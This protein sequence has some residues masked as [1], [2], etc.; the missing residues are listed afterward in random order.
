MTDPTRRTVPEVQATHAPSLLANRLDLSW[1]EP[2]GLHSTLLS[3]ALVV[4]TVEAFEGMVDELVAQSRAT[5]D[6]ALAEAYVAEAARILIE[7]LGRRE[8]AEAL[9]KR[10]EG[11][12]VREMLGAITGPDAGLGREL[13]ALEREATDTSRPAAERADAWVEFGLACEQHT[14]SLDRALAAYRKAL[15]LVPEHPVALQLAA[16]AATLIDEEAAADL[17]DR[18]LHTDL[19]PPLEV[20]ASLWRAEVESDARRSRAFLARARAAD[21][22][23]ETALRRLIRATARDGDLETLGDLYLA[24]ARLAEDPVSRATALHL[25]FLALSDAE[26]RVDDVVAEMLA[27]VRRMEDPRDMVAPLS[28]VALYLERAASLGRDRPVADEIDVLATL[29]PF[30]DDP[31]EQALVREQLARRR[32]ASVEHVLAGANDPLDDATEQMLDALEA[33]LDF[34]LAH[35]PDQHW[36]NET[37]ARLLEARGRIAELVAHLGEWARIQPPGPGRAAIFLELGRVHETYRNDGARAAEAY[38]LALAEHPDDPNC[39]RALGRAYETTR[40]WPQAVS[41]LLRQAEQVDDPLERPTILRRVAT[42]A[43]RELGDTDLAITALEQLASAD[44]DDHLSLFRLVSLARSADR[45]SVLIK[46][47][48]LLTERLDDPVVQTSLLVELGAVHEFKLRQR[49]LAREYYERA[50]DRSPGYTPA[51]RALARIYR[52]DGDLDA[53][54]ALHTPERWPH[55]DP[56]VLAYVAAEFAFEETGASELTVEL[57]RLAYERNPD[58]TAARELLVEVLAASGAF[59]EA[60]A[61]AAAADEPEGPAARADHHYRTG[62]LAEAAARRATGPAAVEA[63]GNAVQHYREAVRVQPS[64]GLAAERTRR[65]LAAFGDLDDLAAAIAQQMPDAPPS[66]QAAYIVQ[67]ARIHLVAGSVEQAKLAFERAFGL[68]SEDPLVARAFETVLAAT[69]DTTALP[70]LYLTLARRVEDRHLQATLL[71][72]AA[73]LLLESGAPEDRDLAA[74][75][76]L[77][78]LRGDPGNP[79]AVRHLERILADPSIQVDVKDAVA[80]RAVRAQS[81]AERATFYL[82]S[83]ELLEGAGLLKQAR[84]AYLAALDAVPG[85]APA[86][87]GLARIAEGREQVV[88]ART[89][90]ASIHALVADMRESVARVLSGDTSALDETITRIQHIL[91]R[92]PGHRDAVGL[93][94]A[95]LERHPRVVE[96]RDILAETLDAVER[97]EDRHALARVLARTAE[98]VQRTITFLE[99]AVAAMPDDVESLRELAAARA[100]SGD[101]LGAV[102]A[103]EQLIER[104]P[105]QDPTRVDLHLEIASDLGDLPEHLDRAIAH[106]E[107]ARALAPRRLDVLATAATLYER[108]DRITDAIAC[109]AAMLEIEEDRRKRHDLLVRLATLESRRGRLDDAIDALERAAVL[110]PGKRE[111]VDMLVDLYARA[112]RPEAAERWVDPTRGVLLADTARGALSLRSVRLLIKVARPSR[113]DLAWAASMLGH[114]LDATSIPAPVD[115][116]QLPVAGGLVELLDRGDLRGKIRSPKEPDALDALAVALEKVM[117]PLAAEFG[118]LRP[119]DEAPVPPGADVRAFSHLVDAWAA[120][121]GASGHPTL[122]ASLTHNAALAIA[123]PE[124]VIRL[125][126][127]L[128]LQGDVPGWRALAAVALARLALGAPRV[129][130]LPPVDLD[131]LLAAA[132]EVSGVFHPLTADPD[133]TR[134]RNVAALLDKHLPRRARRD[135]TAA[136]EELASR[137]LAPLEAARILTSTDLRVALVLTGDPAG[138]LDAAALLDDVAAATRKTRINRSPLAQSLVPFLLSPEFPRLYRALRG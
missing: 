73:E 22:A 57:A 89:G 81:A 93:G 135:T 113:P 35:A 128:W 114:A 40:R 30:L 122:V 60:Y 2:S 23:E 71:V 138:T 41:V 76:I 108:A 36:A 63:A 16:E 52:E 69:E 45:T 17:L 95:V 11:P 97:P 88:A 48:R 27:Q 8:E 59:D 24:L 1:T 12:L 124:T 75:A 127:N 117:G 79:Y 115:H 123:G 104:L 6:P 19:P 5:E 132:F 15:E 14:P 96:L 112:G 61:I 28:E 78:A 94:L 119:E 87:L 105:A 55:A 86:Q 67:I 129:R 110:R 64:H 106:G 9:L 99:Q 10:L 92:H 4:E 32:L 72:E 53:Y 49:L 125:G 29:W 120:A 74:T 100:R 62:L 121:A 50:L 118:V 137:S 38:E 31:R 134:L 68:A 90:P 83:A 136:C 84:R 66:E 103:R 13:A 42:L 26:A 80:A 37:R 18:W 85:L 111:T 116:L 43:E 21:P 44:S 77:D 109:I 70:T 56:A 130:A 91:S 7:R 47:L 101:V 51:L 82:E 20:V 25:S 133:A 131:L 46:A 33:D 65:L 98:D 102:A 126:S 58:L 3:T 107:A 39:L 54:V 34:C